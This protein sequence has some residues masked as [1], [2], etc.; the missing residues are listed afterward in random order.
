M[1]IDS[2]L[3]GVFQDAIRELDEYPGH[4]AY[5]NFRPI[6]AGRPYLTGVVIRDWSYGEQPTH[7]FEYIDGSQRIT[8]DRSIMDWSLPTDKAEAPF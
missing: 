3:I 6:G 8:F 7:Q 2:K 5:L 1:H 4:N